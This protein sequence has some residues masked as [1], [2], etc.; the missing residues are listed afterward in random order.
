MIDVANIRILFGIT[1][2]NV[3]FFYRY[4]LKIIPNPNNSK[5]LRG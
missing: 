3:K 4:I 1:M 2:E 5:G